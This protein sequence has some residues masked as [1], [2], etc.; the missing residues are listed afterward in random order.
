MGDC[1]VCVFV[2]W[3]PWLST[4][5]TNKDNITKINKKKFDL[6]FYPSAFWH[7]FTMAPSL[8]GQWSTHGNFPPTSSSSSAI[9]SYSGLGRIWQRKR[10]SRGVVFYIFFIYLTENLFTKDKLRLIMRLD[11]II[12]IYCTTNLYAFVLVFL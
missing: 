2:P 7:I 6:V 1:L 5:R 11:F 8:R 10:M 12:D 4:I 3:L 9:F